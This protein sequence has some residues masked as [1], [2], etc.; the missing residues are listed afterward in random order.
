[1]KK[2]KNVFF[3]NRNYHIPLILGIKE[4]KIACSNVP[5]DEDNE[6]NDKDKKPKKDPTTKLLY[7]YPFGPKFKKGTR[8][9]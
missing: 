3:S 4:V 8:R 5:E 6:E 9:K 1:M 7:S 2:Y